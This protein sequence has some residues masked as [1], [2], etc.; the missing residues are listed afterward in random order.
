LSLLSAKGIKKSY[1]KEEVLRNINLDINENDFIMILGRSGGGKTTLLNVLSTVDVKDVKGELLFNNKNLLRESECD[2]ANFRKKYVGYVFQD[3]ALIPEFSVLENAML[4]LILNKVPR[5]EAEKKAYKLL[6]SVEIPKTHFNKKPFELSGGQQQRVAI[7]RAII[8]DPKILFAD[9]PTGNLDE[10]SAL[11]VV[12]LLKDISKNRAVIL[13]T[14]T[15]T[16]FEIIENKK[17]LTLKDG[18]LVDGFNIT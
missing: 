1:G 7:V 3:F 13:I 16:I 8:K 12:E 6:D 5:K 17:V 14:H 11:K 9:E 4:P 15:P 18:L 10:K 2:R